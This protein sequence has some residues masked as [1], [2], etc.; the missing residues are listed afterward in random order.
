MIS[1]RPQGAILAIVD[2]PAM[3]DSVVPPKDRYDLRDEID[4]AAMRPETRLHHLIDTEELDEHTVARLAALDGATVLDRSA[5][6][7]AYGAIVTTSDSEHEGARTAAA[8]TL[9]QTALV[10]LKVSVDGDI[11]IFRDGTAVTTLLGRP[12]A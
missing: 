5:R 2:D 6:L 11:T 7:L 8:R 12:T 4:H 1:A 3:L 10:V 9:S